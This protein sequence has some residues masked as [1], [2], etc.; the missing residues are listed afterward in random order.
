MMFGTAAKIDDVV[1]SYDL[2]GNRTSMTRYQNLENQTEA[3]TT[4]WG[5]DSL[6]RVTKLKEDGVAEHTR[7]YNSWG[8]LTV[9]QWCNDSSQAPCPGADRRTIAYYDARNRVT[10]REDQTDN[11]GQPVPGTAVDF[12]YD[13]NGG[14]IEG[15]PRNNMLGRLASAT[16]RPAKYGLPTMIRAGSTHA[17]SWTRAW[18][19]M[20]TTTR[21]RI[22]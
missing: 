20:T 2:L 22:P 4:H 3:V 13:A 1:F 9:E 18:R 10:H 6:G 8:N 5:Y 17:H 21:L 19:L 15:V 12:S 14:V 11:S 16:G 7:T